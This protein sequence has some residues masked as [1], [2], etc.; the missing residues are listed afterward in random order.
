MKRHAGRPSVSVQRSPRALPMAALLVGSLAVAACQLGTDAD[1]GVDSRQFTDVAVPSGFR[2]QDRAH[3]SYSRIEASWRHAHLVYKGN[4]DITDAAAYVVRSMPR[5]SWSKV[6][7]VNTEEERR[8]RFE[9]GIYSADY[10]F[11]RRDG[12]T[13]MVVDYATDYSKR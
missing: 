5:H 4:D 3:E 7:E 9:R 2:L 11:T 8:L 1:V 6:D 10:V 13:Q 12:M